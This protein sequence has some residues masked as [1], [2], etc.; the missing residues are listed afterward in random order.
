L[1]KLALNV[2]D[3]YQGGA[4]GNVVISGA[5]LNPVIGGNVELANGKVLLTQQVA[6]AAKPLYRVLVHLNLAQRNCRPQLEQS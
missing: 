6:A 1:N 2:K 4:N 5:A 3:L